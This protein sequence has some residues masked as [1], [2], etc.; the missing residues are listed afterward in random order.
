M[1]PIRCQCQRLAALTDS[2]T[3]A[4]K[5]SPWG[6]GH[7]ARAR[8]AL[9]SA[10]AR[11]ENVTCDGQPMSPWEAAELLGLTDVVRRYYE[12]DHA[13]TKVAAR[14]RLAARR[15]VTSHKNHL[16]REARRDT[17]AAVRAQRQ[18]LREEATEAAQNAM[19][20]LSV[21]QRA[22]FARKLCAILGVRVEELPV[23]LRPLS[24]AYFRKVADG[25]RPA[26]AD[27]IEVELVDA[28]KGRPRSNP[29][30]A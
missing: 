8:A 7:N 25:A 2:C 6:V 19:I 4:P 9:V 27:H 3:A 24:A 28:P 22:E 17:A 23:A 29:P 21:E 18:R 15:A 16:D 30:V 12:R 14:E 26:P 1:L 5:T 20:M 10:L 11:G 13:P